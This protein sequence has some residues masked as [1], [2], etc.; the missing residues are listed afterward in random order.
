[1]IYDSSIKWDAIYDVIV[2]GFG[3]AGAG[4]ARFAADN[5]AHVLLIDS[6]PEGQEGGNTRYAGGA[7]AWSDNFNDLREY[8]KETYYPFKYDPKGLDT[9]V[10]N[11]LQMKE[12]SKKY[13]GIEAQYTGRRPKGEYP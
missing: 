6:A 3:G 2:I 13:F 1:M 8:Y 9:F 7:F 5:N 4:A 11:V 10:N 12:Y